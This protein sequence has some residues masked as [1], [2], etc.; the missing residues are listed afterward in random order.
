MKTNRLKGFTLVELIVVIAIIGVLASILV[1]N[2]MG[3]IQKAKAKQALADAKTVQNVL[4]T[5]LAS[6]SVSL[7]YSNLDKLKNGSS[8]GY[9]IVDVDSIFDQTLGGTYEGIIYDFDYTSS[10]F[11]FAYSTV[12]LPQYRVFYNINSID[13]NYDILEENVFTVAKKKS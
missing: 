13:S 3:Y 10:G 12:T 4:S 5:E 6:A 2:M 7:N 8:S 9:K 11:E 1:P